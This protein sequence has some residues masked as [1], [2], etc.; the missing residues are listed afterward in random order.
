MHPCPVCGK[1]FPRPSGLRIHMNTHDHVKPYS[2]DF[3][4]CLRM[5][6]VKSNAKRH[7][8]THGINPELMGSGSRPEWLVGFEDPQV[9]PE[10]GHP[11]SISPSKFR[12]MPPFSSREPH[13]ATKSEGDSGSELDE[14][15]DDLTQR[16]ESFEM[17]DTPL[18]TVVSSESERFGEDVDSGQEMKPYPGYAYLPMSSR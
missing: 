17:A 14:P 18:R 5:F 6:T 11:S 1:P 16:Y 8:R 7:L 10:G 2:C 4:G 12:W 9:V 3:P 13:V 15:E